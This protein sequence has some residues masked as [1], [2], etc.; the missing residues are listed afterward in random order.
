[1]FA[2]PDVA[3][4]PRSMTMAR[5]AMRWAAGSSAGLRHEPV[6]FAWAR[7]LRARRRLLHPRGGRAEERGRHSALRALGPRPRRDLAFEEPVRARPGDRH[8]ARPGL[9][10]PRWPPAGADAMSPIL[11]L[12]TA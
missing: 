2:M 12:A 7:C 8:A 3:S 4:W 10:P 5:C 9:R 6:R 1:C 11:S